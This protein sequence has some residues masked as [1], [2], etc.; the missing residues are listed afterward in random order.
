MTLAAFCNSLQSKDYPTAYIQ[1]SSDIKRVHAEAQFETDFTGLT[2][3]YDAASSSGNAVSTTM[4]FR[5]ATGQVAK[6][7]VHLTQVSN[8]NNIW[9]INSIQF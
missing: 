6:A 8:S 4:T 3:S 1:L 5:D 7:T 9:K 2:C